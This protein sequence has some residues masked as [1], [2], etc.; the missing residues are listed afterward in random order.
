[1]TKLPRYKNCFV[2]GV[3][4]KA[5]LD[6]QFYREG[7]RVECSWKPEEK[8]LGYSDRVHGGVTAAILDETMGWTPSAEYRRLCISIE[9]N[10]KY[11]LPIA[12]GRSFRVEAE[13]LELKHR[14]SRTQGRVVDDEGALYATAT[15]LYVPLPPG[16]T[17][18]VLE[19]L[20]IEGIDRS[21][22]L[23]DL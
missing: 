5:G 19:Y 2:C 12:A 13:A 1:M 23:D 21:V 18:K 17:E 10:V 7:N 16:D 15:G 11:R 20:Y 8:H 4:N 6:I 14:A 9:I 22:T 3:A